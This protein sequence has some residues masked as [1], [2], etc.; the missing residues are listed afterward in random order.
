MR[1]FFSL[2]WPGRRSGG[3]LMRNPKPSVLVVDD[4]P[5]IRVCLS[6][7]LTEGGYLVRDAP[8]G[9]SALAEIREEMP[10]LIV[11]DLNMPNMSG[12]ELLSVVRRRFPSIRAIA[13]SSAFPGTEFPAGVPAD[14]FYEKGSP[15]RSLLAIV[16][17]ITR[18][19]TSPLVHRPRSLAPIWIPT[20]GH[21]TSGEMYVT[22]SCPECLRAFPQVIDRSAS[23][24]VETRCAWCCVP[25][26]YAIVRPAVAA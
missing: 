25:I 8:D 10:D 24:T 7:I 6:E 16:E 22:I 4:Q 11:S 21:N 5:L 12:F 17:D 2:H 15:T 18:P 20:N 26:R 19:R 3:E 23:A 14:A 13:M 9:F 1:N